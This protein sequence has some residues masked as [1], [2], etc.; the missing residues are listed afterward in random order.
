MA[1]RVEGA[2]KPG[3]R[4]KFTGAV[5][6]TLLELLLSGQAGAHGNPFVVFT[7]RI[8]DAAG[9]PASGLILS[10]DAG[11]TRAE[12]AIESGRVEVAMPFPRD[13]AGTLRM[14][15]LDGKRRVISLLPTQGSA[16]TAAGFAYRHRP[17]DAIRSAL[18]WDGASTGS[19]SGQAVGGGDAALLKDGEAVLGGDG[20]IREGKADAPAFRV[21]WLPERVEPG[22]AAETIRGRAL[23]RGIETEF[24]ERLEA[25]RKGRMGK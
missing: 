15:V 8:L 11:E 12:A 17:G 2:G 21:D 3:C 14:R 24:R 19:A 18:G 20:R 23:D 1:G 9:R 4:A 25:L 6:A 22:E 10:L 7:T 5:I 16:V 13:F